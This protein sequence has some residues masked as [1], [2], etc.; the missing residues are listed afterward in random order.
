MDPSADANTNPTDAASRPWWV[1][2]AVLAIGAF[3]LY[4]ASLL[5][6]G[7][8]HARV[9]PGVFVALTGGGLVLLGLVLLAQIARGA[10][11]ETQDSEDAASDQ[12]ADWTA[13][14]TAVLAASLPLYTMERFGFVLTAALMFALIA[15]A[16]GS[17]RLLVDIAI[18][19]V[20]AAACWFG[21]SKLGVDLGRAWI[22]P[23]LVDLIPRFSLT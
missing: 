3:W 12:P 11:F 19:A 6:F 4:G 14:G 10:R 23:K 13:F 2:F 20:L 21:F 16:F 7:S 9:G 22:V 1:G 8:T 17:R 5:Q 18:G 15:R